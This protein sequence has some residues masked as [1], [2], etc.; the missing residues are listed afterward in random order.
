[1]R[2][3]VAAFD[4]GFRNF[5]FCILDENKTS[6]PVAWRNLQLCSSTNQVVAALHAWFD[7]NH[8]LFA[9]VTHVVLER[10][11]RSPFLEMNA[12]L[13]TLFRD[14]VVVVVHPSAV[15]AMFRLPRQREAKKKATVELVRNAVGNAF[16]PGAKQD[17]LA[18]AWLL[19]LYGLNLHF[20]K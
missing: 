18:D 4:A 3:R 2:R 7:E 1:M 11:M 5:A 8:K 13:W 20:P 6:N 10:Q 17:D 15:G 19:A 14:R 9:D 16:P 12:I